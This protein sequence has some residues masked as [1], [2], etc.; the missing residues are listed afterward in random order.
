MT[1]VLYPSPTETAPSIPPRVRLTSWAQQHRQS[2]ALGAALLIACG[3]L[4]AINLNGWPERVGDDEGTY[5]A[6]AWAMLSQGEITYY[7]YWYDHPFGG[8]LQ[9]AGLFRI[10]DVLNWTSTAVEAARDTMLA[11]HV[12]SCGLVFLIA[13]RLGLRRPLA[14]LAVVLFSLSPL[15]LQYQR[16]ALLDNISTMWV[17]AA[18][19]YALSPRRSLASVVGV[20]ASLALAFWSKETSVLLTPGVFWMAW[21]NRDVR[22]WRYLRAAGMFVFVAIVGIWPL[23]ALIKNEL[24]PGAGHVSLTTAVQFQLFSRASSGSLLTAGSGTRKLVDTWLAQDPLLMWGGLAAGLLALAVRRLRPVAFL[25]LFQAVAMCRDGYL[26]YAYVTAM[27]PF[28][29]LSIAGVANALPWEWLRNVAGIRRLTGIGVVAVA[30]AL[31]GALVVADWLPHW[32]TAVTAHEERPSYAGEQWIRANV[33]R[34]A[35]IV[36]DDNVWTDLTRSG[37]QHAVWLYK[38]DLD[39]AV[40]A[41]LPNGWRSVDYVAVGA[42]DS[43]T[44]ANSPQVAAALQH[45]HVVADYGAFKVYQV[46]KTL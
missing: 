33:P 16:M 35:T 42:L 36:V 6:Q 19:V 9:I 43:D 46:D 39:P 20:G 5:A 2:L 44:L 23:Y 1:A 3:L 37:F 40:R 27:I 14:G 32:Q 25:F 38:V 22:N 11:F 15:A 30:V 17:L 41:T 7:T 12:V 10:S 4:H 24:F 18:A 8:W 21:Q 29:A 26:P 34:E 45:S 13:R 31:T 28:A